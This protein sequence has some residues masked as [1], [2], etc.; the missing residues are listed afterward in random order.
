MKPSSHNIGIVSLAFVMACSSMPSMA[1][2]SSQQQAAPAPAARVLG[3]LTAIT[4]NTL[5]IK[6]DAGAESQVTVGES[7]RMVRTAP[8]EKTLS[9]ATPI[10]LTDLAV[11]DRVLVRAA[12]GAD[13]SLLIAMKQSDIAQRQ[14]QQ[15]EDWQRRGIS[16]LVKAV[17]PASGT[18]NVNIAA[19]TAP[20]PLTIETTP[21][22]VVRQ[23]APDSVKYDD[24]KP[25]SVGQI[26]PGDQLRA[27][28]DRE[29]GTLKAEEIV[30]GAFRNIAGSILAAD[31]AAQTITVLDLATK[32]PA[33]IHLNNQSQIHKLPPEMAQMIARQL[34]PATPPTAAAAGHQPHP[35][36][37]HGAPEGGA[38]PR[39]GLAQILQRAPTITLADL[40]KGEAVMIVASD[41]AAG[42]VTAIT[43]LAG[44]E[45]LLQA[46]PGASES[47]FSAS[48][49]LGGGEGAADAQQPQ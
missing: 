35:E 37:A 45:S 20:R 1:A 40:H 27:R 48:W 33:V 21:A 38:Q 47:V 30:F 31:N 8:G 24:A 10:K 15:R 4:G 9:G 7:T 19:G 32:K 44:V 34:K 11:G 28:G 36:M 29:G 3:T 41:A 5:T 42:Q 2:K 43:V 25:S 22:T 23:Y 46:S 6:S 13:A 26:K 16:G 39:E 17:D 18:I 12:P 14:Q 49:S